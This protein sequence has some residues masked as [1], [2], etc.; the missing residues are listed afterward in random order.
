MQATVM[1]HRVQ[2]P[3]YSC[4][5]ICSTVELQAD[6][7]PHICMLADLLNGGAR[8]GE[9]SAGQQEDELDLSDAEAASEEDAD[10]LDEVDEEA[11]EDVED[12]V[13]AGRHKKPKPNQTLLPTEDRY[14]I[15]MCV[16]SPLSG[17]HEP[18]KP[19]CDGAF[20][21]YRHKL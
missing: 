19:F 2:N 3:I 6:L 21:S 8:S 11:D 10:M 9:D 16:L 13:E 18:Y 14:V 12:Q 15:L 20:A 17:G 7:K 1:K 4:L 5:Q